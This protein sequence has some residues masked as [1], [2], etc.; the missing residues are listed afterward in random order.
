MA[1]LQLV[2]AFAG[3]ACACALA[4]AAAPVTRVYPTGSFPLDMQNVQ[5]AIDGGGTVL[6]KATNLAGT[7]T[8]FDFGPPDPV[9]DGGVTLHT[10]VS[11]VGETVHGHMTTINGGFNP[12]LGLLPVR[13]RIQGIDFEG[14]LDSPI[15]L[16]SSSGA[17]IIGNRIR[18]IVPLP[19]FFGT[20]I[21]GIFVS[22]FDD[23][24][25]AVT[26]R[27]RVLDNS[28]EISGGDFVNG[29][30]FDEVAA[31]I[32][33]SGNN[34]NFLSSDGEVQTI[35]IL[36]FRS[37]GE[38]TVV[39]NQVTMGNGDPNAFPSGIFVGG[40]PE[41]HYTIATNRIV[42]NHPAA[43]GI[44][45]LG[46]PNSGATV[47]ALVLAN[48]VTTHSTTDFNGGIVFQGGVQN[49]IVAGNVLEGTTGSAIQIIG[50]DGTLVADSNLALGNDIA[51]M[52][53]AAGDVFF[54]PDSSNNLFIGRCNT[55]TDLG[56]NN[57]ITCGH[58]L[59]AAAAAAAT[60][61]AASVRGTRPPLQLSMDELHR[62]RA[63]ALQPRLG[64]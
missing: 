64:R 62:A 4:Y 34:V 42:T 25:H 26:G 3:A 12:I 23:P 46:L 17:D 21:E 60:P 18:G 7:P 20:E 35:G 36:V 10:D 43:D 59:A 61:F 14:P 38:A 2:A 22:G 29:M 56:T 9:V 47:G 37:H 57:R 45:V 44:D 54:G 32:E 27:I 13:S 28:I 24:L 8:A 50:I 49:S 11:I 31:D 16:I 48:R 19:L 52:S 1:R 5:T 63:Q 33:I 53:S 30:Q 6:L 40:H 39:N 15:A 55:F 58:A 51:H 41:A